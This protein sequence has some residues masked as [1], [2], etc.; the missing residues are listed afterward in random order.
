MQALTSPR[1]SKVNG[2]AHNVPHNV[3]GHG[4]DRV[5]G[6]HRAVGSGNFTARAVL[7]CLGC[8]PGRPWSCP[9]CPG[10]SEPERP[11]L[12]AGG[13]LGARPTLD[14]GMYRVST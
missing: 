1:L 12:C 4:G 11:N 13:P 3:P 5:F 14:M 9:G 8:P 7:C 2:V 6:T 10:I